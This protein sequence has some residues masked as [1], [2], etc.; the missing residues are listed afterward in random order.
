[1]SRWRFGVPVSNLGGTARTLDKVNGR[2]ELEQGI[3]SVVSLSIDLV[4]T[5]CRGWRFQARDPRLKRLLTVLIDCWVANRM[6][7]L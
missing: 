2:C 5:D 1:M 7:L 6:A 4:L 3:L